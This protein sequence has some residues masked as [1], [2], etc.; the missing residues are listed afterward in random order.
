MDIPAGDSVFATAAATDE[1][2]L[3]GESL[4]CGALSENAV[5]V[6]MDGLSVRPDLD[7]SIAAKSGMGQMLGVTFGQEG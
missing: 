4:C 3:T 6:V 1:T 7:S 2:G 5:D